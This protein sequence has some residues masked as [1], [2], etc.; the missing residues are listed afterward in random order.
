MA[1]P[2]IVQRLVGLIGHT[3]TM[4]LIDEFGGQTIRF[5]R[6]ETTALFESL[7]ETI[8]RTATLTLGAELG[9]W[10]ADERYIPFCRDA[11]R[12]DRNRAIINRY[13]ALLAGGHSCRGA[14]SVLVREHKLS[15]RQIQKIVNQPLPAPS[16][17][18]VQ[19]ALF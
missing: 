17:A 1:L 2:E 8:G 6:D 7:V 14:I 11:I 9:G 15:N 13:D 16:E 10:Q 19:G 12:A 5:P 4:A 3:K 18:A